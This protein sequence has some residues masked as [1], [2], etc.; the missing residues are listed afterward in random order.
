M[1]LV[2]CAG[3][4]IGALAMYG[5]QQERLMALPYGDDASG[6]EYFKH[7][8]FLVLNNRIVAGLAGLVM[9][10]VK[11]ES[12]AGGP[13]IWKYLV[14]AISNIGATYCQ[15]EALKYVSFPTQTL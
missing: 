12:F 14:I 9:I 8:V 7:T 1:L 4:I 5:Y 2:A 15:Y 11:G 13:A 6:Q 3:G 10:F